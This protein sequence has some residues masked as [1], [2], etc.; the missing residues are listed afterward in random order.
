MTDD[1]FFARLS[2]C[3]LPPSQFDH[4]GHLRL[5]AICLQRHGVDEAIAR[6]CGVIGRYAVS[7]GAPDKFHWTVTEALMRL[8]HA[9]VAL[10]GDARALLAQHYSAQLLASEQARRRFVAPDLAPLPG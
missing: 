8:L 3:S 10:T 5:A 7:L 6:A 2:D 9:R 1:Q 4:A